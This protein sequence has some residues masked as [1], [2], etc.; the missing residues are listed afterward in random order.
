MPIEPLAPGL[1]SM[2]QGWPSV[3]RAFSP[4]ARVSVSSTPP[5]GN[6]TITRIGRSG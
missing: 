6:G 1:F 3:V 5:A 4:I 2:I